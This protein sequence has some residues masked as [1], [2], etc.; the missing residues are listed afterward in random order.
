MASNETYHPRQRMDAAEAEAH[1]NWL[2]ALINDRR[3]SNYLHATDTFYDTKCFLMLRDMQ[4]KLAALAS[5]L[6]SAI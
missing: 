1:L 5:E 3:F 2:S 4:A 6:H